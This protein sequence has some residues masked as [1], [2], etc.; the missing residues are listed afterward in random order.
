[1]PCPRLRFSC[2]P[3]SRLSDGR[4]ASCSSSC[5]AA[6]IMAPVAAATAR[7]VR[8]D[9]SSGS[10]KTSGWVASPHRRARLGCA[11]SAAQD[12]LVIGR[13]R[14]ELAT[15]AASLYTAVSR[16]AQSGSSQRGLAAR[17]SPRSPPGTPPS[18]SS[19]F[20]RRIPHLARQLRSASVCAS[21]SLIAHFTRR[22]STV[23]GRPHRRRWR[24]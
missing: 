7:P 6:D 8:I 4:V 24:S 12:R 22:A 11:P 23:G 20:A 10:L 14:G 17:R 2:L 16:W 9:R 21:K 19:R 3:L 1:M 13:G 15:W 5:S 18:R